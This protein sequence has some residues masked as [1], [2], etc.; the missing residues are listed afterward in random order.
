MLIRGYLEVRHLRLKLAVL[1]R[2]YAWDVGL[3]VWA[4][5]SV[6]VME[7][8]CRSH[9]CNETFALAHLMPIPMRCSCCC[10]HGKCPKMRHKHAHEFCK[11]N[12]SSGSGCGSCTNKLP[13]PGNAAQINEAVGSR[14]WTWTWACGCSCSCS[15]DMD[16]SANIIAICNFILIFAKALTVDRSSFSV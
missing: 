4:R 2:I 10:R 3:C 12:N 5:G 14:P 8:G 6:A 7:R 1:A 15:W 13:L 9:K 11:A 16:M